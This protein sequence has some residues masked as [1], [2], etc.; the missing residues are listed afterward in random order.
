MAPALGELRLSKLTDPI[1]VE[2]DEIGNVGLLQDREAGTTHGGGDEAL[3]KAGRE[4]DRVEA[5]VDLALQD[6]DELERRLKDEVSLT[7]GDMLGPIP[8]ELLEGSNEALEGA[9]GTA[10]RER[11]LH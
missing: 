5:A 10:P 8:G 9:L 7:Q 4:T 1:G 11:A 6:V 3:E 2:A